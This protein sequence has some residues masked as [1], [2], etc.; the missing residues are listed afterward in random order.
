MIAQIWQAITLTTEADTYAD[1]LDVQVLPRYRKA[2]GNQGVYALRS[3]KGEI[4]HFLLLSMW[5]SHEELHRFA[6]PDEGKIKIPV[7]EKCYLLA[8]ESIVKYY[9]IIRK[10]D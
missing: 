3:T 2:Q 7:E 9:E 6:G 8:F 10:I 5:S 1:Y 4:T